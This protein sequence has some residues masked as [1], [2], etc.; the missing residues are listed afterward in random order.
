LKRLPVCLAV[1]AALAVGPGTASAVPAS[2]GGGCAGASAADPPCDTNIT[3]DRDG[4]GY[5]NEQDNCQDVWNPDQADTDKDAGPP[6]YLP[7]AAAPRNPTAGG[8]AC[9]IDDDSDG[10]NDP[11][12]NCPRAP[13]KDQADADA[14]GTGDVCDASGP[15][16]GTPAPPAT[17][18]ATPDPASDGQPPKLQIVA[19]PRIQRLAEVR[20]GVTVAVRCSKRCSIESRLLVDRRTARRLRLPA[21]RGTVEVGRGGAGLEAAGRTYV[22]VRFGRGVLARIARAGRVSSLLRLVVSDDTGHRAVVQRRLALRS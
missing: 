16:A 1:V 2:A 6:P 22:F 20:A 17:P 8:D 12:D 11:D 13:N 14:D 10:V 7:S 15:A 18:R 21:A 3:A 19:L 4:D 9:D 5:N